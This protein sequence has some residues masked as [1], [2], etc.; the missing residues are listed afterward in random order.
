MTGAQ[1]DLSMTK[2]PPSSS[3]AKGE[4]RAETKKL[5][6]DDTTPK[7]KLFFGLPELNGP[8]T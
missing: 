6:E 7:N 8:Q 2:P 3:R 5:P 4:T 1:E